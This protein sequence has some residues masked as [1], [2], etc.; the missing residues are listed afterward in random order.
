MSNVFYPSLAVLVIPGSR[1]LQ[2][3]ARRIASTI[4][5]E[6]VREYMLLG[7]VCCFVALKA[8]FGFCFFFEQGM[9]LCMWFKFS[10]LGGSW[11]TL[12]ELSNGYCTEHVYV[13]RYAD[14]LDLVFGVQHS[15][16]TVKAEQCTAN[17]TGISGIPGTWQHLCWTVLHSLNALLLNSTSSS[18]SSSD[19]YLL[20]ESM[21]EWSS[22][23]TSF[24][25]ASSLVGMQAMSSYDATW[26]VYINGRL[27][28]NSV[29]GAMPVEG[30]YS[31]NYI[32]YGTMFAASF[33]NWAITDFRFYERPL[34]T[35]SIQAIFSGHACCSTFAAGSYINS[36]K[37]C[38]AESTYNSEFC[39]SCKSDCGPLFFIKNEDN[40]CNGRRTADFT[41]CQP[42]SAC[43]KD[44]YPSA[45]AKDQ[46]WGIH[47]LS[48]TKFLAMFGGE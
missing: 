14:S 4:V 25:A 31:V 7:I 46:E 28:L 47:T 5:W 42:C 13:R 43:A 45:C 26:S 17:C 37:Q 11:Q 3:D 9:T 19:L 41:L 34:N 10:T 29:P 22:M 44:Q 35:S 18:S 20:P 24:S 38:Q 15:G 2:G 27:L 36:S 12:F 30:S 21:F 32:A 39:R 8:D 23:P 1:K 40:A 33:F 16:G 48:S 6:Q